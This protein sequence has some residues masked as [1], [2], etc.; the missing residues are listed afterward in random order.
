MSE[1]ITPASV[2]DRLT[3]LGIAYRVI[4]HEAVFTCEQAEAIDR[5]LRGAACKNL[6]LRNRE[7]TAH[8]LIVTEATKRVDLAVLR[9]L[10]GASKL[11][12]C[13]PERLFAHLGLTPG[14][15]SPF[16]L[17]NDV[18]K[19]VKVVID[20]DLFS[21][22]FV[23]FHPNVNIATVEITPV[24]FEKFLDATGHDWQ[25]IAIPVVAETPERGD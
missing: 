2:Y 9:H 8:F 10:I 17:V 19:R 1:A 14:S 6:F 21:A 13:S 25:R 22:P 18:E 16:G 5:N 11:G 20:E 23:N 7:G 24:D 12:F 4:D 15:V 3:Q